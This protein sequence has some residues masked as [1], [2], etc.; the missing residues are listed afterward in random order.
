MSILDD[1]RQESFNNE[2][3]KIAVSAKTLGY[4]ALAASAVP[5]LGISHYYDKKKSYKYRA[6]SY[7]DKIKYDLGTDYMMERLPGKY[8]TSGK[9]PHRT[10]TA[11]LKQSAIS[12]IG[13]AGVI[14]AAHLGSKLVSK[15]ETG[16]TKTANLKHIGI[17]AAGVV[18]SIAA[19][20]TGAHMGAKKGMEEGTEAYKKFW[21]KRSQNKVSKKHY[22]MG[23]ASLSGKSTSEKKKLVNSIRSLY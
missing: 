21:S 17:G 7:H 10:K 8:F 19:G 14:G 9:N 15:K 20:Y 22:E 11:N 23:L 18:G 12:A 5:L 4:G 13:L 16:K 3:E 1:I 2:L 6:Q